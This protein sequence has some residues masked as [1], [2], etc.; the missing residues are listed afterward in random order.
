M[1]QRGRPSQYAVPAR[2]PIAVV[3]R[4]Q[5]P[6][7]FSPKALEIWTRIV[8][9]YPEDWFPAG[10]AILL[11]QLCAH[12]EEAYYIRKLLANER[13][14]CDTQQYNRLLMMQERQTQMLVTL[15]TKL[16]LTPQSTTN[17]RGNRLPGSTVNLPPW[18]DDLDQLE[19]TN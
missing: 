10:A 1:I 9:S 6:D 8:T 11:E 5:P 2:G 14:C 4:L 18:A 15:C 17:H 12:A 16:K 3:D 7:D 19:A 13:D